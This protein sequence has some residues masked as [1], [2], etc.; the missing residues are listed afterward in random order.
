MLLVSLQVQLVTTLVERSDR[1]MSTVAYALTT[2]DNPYDPFDEFDSWY[3][4]DI[5]RELTHRDENYVNCCSILD[6]FAHTSD[7]LSD[8]ENIA[9][10]EDAINRII[11]IDLMGV[12]KKVRRVVD[13]PKYDENETHE[14]GIISS[15]LYKNKK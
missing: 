10:I 8:S 14:D 1:N 3:M 6:R 15:Q 7:A 4:F 9:I 12:Y 5:N 2:I 13:E 11:K